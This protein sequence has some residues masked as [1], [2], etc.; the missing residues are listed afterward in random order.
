MLWAAVTNPSVIW[1]GMWELNPPNQI[2][3]LGHNRYANA[4]NISNFQTTP[5]KKRSLFWEAPVVAVKTK[6]TLQENLPMG[7]GMNSY[8]RNVTNLFSFL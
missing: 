6:I 8:I 3:N 5:A 2:G 1:S 7:I 4:A